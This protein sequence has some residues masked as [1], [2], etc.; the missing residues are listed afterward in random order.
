M[1]PQLRQLERKYARELVVIGVHSAKFMAEK[2][3]ENL[4][5]AILRYDIAHPVI[6]DADFL[7]WQTYGVN[8]WPTFF[9]ISPAGK[10]IGKHAGELPPEPIDRILTEMVREYDASGLIDR[11]PLAFA[12]EQLPDTPLRFPGKVA[13][14]AANERL[15]VADSGHHRLV[16]A[17]L[18]GVVQQVAGSGAPGLHDGP[19]ATAT[20]NAPQGIAVAPDGDV[21]YVADTENHAIRRVDLVAG[22]VETLAG[23]GEQARRY[24]L[25]GPGREV[26][27][28]SPWDLARAGDT[29]YIAMA[30]FHQVWSLDLAGPDCTVAPYAGSGRENIVDG[31]L[32]EAQLAQPSGITTDGERLYSAD[33]E[34]SAVRAI[35]LDPGGGQ[36][37]TLVGV[38]LFDFGDADGVGDAVRLQHPLGVCAYEGTLYIADTYNHK[39]KQLDPRGRA[40]TTIAGSEPG[41]AD[42][43]AL[44]ARFREPSGLAAANGKLYIA[45][46]NSHAIRVVHLSTGEVT[47]LALR[48]L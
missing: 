23:T 29:L 47:T 14:D 9:F 18:D 28:N 22:T 2:A 10:V 6:N 1:L 41:H 42:G 26:E 20:F 40:V 21:L 7:V 19:L 34:T 15:I 44:Q 36:V 33:S 39:I 25:A 48:G 5:E 3:T 16:L 12:R 27:L 30:G 4:R 24:L 43:P 13:V 11:R 32:S 17:S 46:T 8:A 38:G 37:H 31:L 35:D 45:D